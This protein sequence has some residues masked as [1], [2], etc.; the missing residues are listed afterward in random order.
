[1]LAVWSQCVQMYGDC[2][3]PRPPHFVTCSSWEESLGVSSS[4][5]CCLLSLQGSILAKKIKLFLRMLRLSKL[6]TYHI[7]DNGLKVLLFKV[8]FMLL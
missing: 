2:L 4:A 7:D 5:V 6:Y 8:D 1:M 3:V